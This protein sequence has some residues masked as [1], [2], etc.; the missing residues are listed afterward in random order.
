[1]FIG[2]QPF[3]KI[4]ISQKQFFFL[5]PYRFVSFYFIKTINYYLSFSR[6]AAP[7]CHSFSSILSDFMFKKKK[8][9]TN[10]SVVLNTQNMQ[11][12][13]YKDGIHVH[14]TRSSRLMGDLQIEE[15]EY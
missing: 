3:R 4:K 8:K 15:E 7:P 5:L 13:S 6:I 12:R 9:I 1:M 11:I 14:C 2:H 10:I